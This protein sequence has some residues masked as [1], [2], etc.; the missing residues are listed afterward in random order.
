MPVSEWCPSA[1]HRLTPSITQHPTLS[2]PDPRI[3]SSPMGGYGC[4]HSALLFS[5][6]SLFFRTEEDDDTTIGIHH[7]QVKPTTPPPS[8]RSALTEPP[9]STPSPQK[10]QSLKLGIREARFAPSPSTTR[11]KPHS[12]RNPKRIKKKQ[13]RNE[14][15]SPGRRGVGDGG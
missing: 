8:Q 13:Q 9:T 14:P 2:H 11:T 4:R 3:R 1:S 7:Q 15:T 10:S 12:F 6:R 5:R